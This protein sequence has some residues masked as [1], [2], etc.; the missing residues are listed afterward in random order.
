MGKF[1]SRVSKAKHVLSSLGFS[2]TIRRYH[3]KDVLIIPGA[4]LT[5]KGRKTKIYSNNEELRKILIAS[6]A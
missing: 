1:A 5:F 4:S 3:S 6:I 2:V